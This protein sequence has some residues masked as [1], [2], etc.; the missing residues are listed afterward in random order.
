MSSYLNKIEITLI[1]SSGVQ[2][3][4]TNI[5]MNYIRGYIQGNE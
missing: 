3:V 1:L 5:L 4:T 2:D